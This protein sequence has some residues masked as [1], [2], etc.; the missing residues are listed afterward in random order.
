MAGFFGMVES[1]PSIFQTRNLKV[2]GVTIHVRA[3]G[4]GSAVVMLHGFGDTGDMWAPAAAVLA[5][6]HRIVVHDLRGMGLSSHPESGYN[7]KTQA[8]IATVMDKL[9][10]ENAAFVTHDIGNM[11]GYAFAAQFP[12]RV[13]RWV[14]IGAPL[15]GIGPWDEIT[16][17]PLLWHFNFR[18]PD[19]ERLVKAASAFT[20]AGFG[21]NFLPIPNESKSRRGATTRAP[22]PCIAHSINLRPSLTT[23]PIIRGQRQADDA[24]I[25]PRRRSFLRCKNGRH[26]ETGCGECIRRCYRQV[27]ALG[28]GRTAETDDR[29][30]CRFHRKVGRPHFT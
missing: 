7:K 4:Q 30:H 27:G 13:S 23:P 10:I 16:R 15:P 17:S 28:H 11:V 14:V 22:A 20:S 8:D 29:G 1:F 21:T 9:R 3:G 26:H 18:G 25:G 12:A 5:K 2:N 24:R 6:D 19:V